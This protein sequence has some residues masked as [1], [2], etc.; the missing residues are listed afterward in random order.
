MLNGSSEELVGEATIILTIV[1]TP[2]A[3]IYM[4]IIGWWE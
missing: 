4:N 1:L 3:S 2:A